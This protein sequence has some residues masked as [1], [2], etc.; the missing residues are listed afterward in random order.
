VPYP[1]I[2]AND[3]LSDLRSGRLQGAAVLVP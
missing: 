3:A 1:L 2:R